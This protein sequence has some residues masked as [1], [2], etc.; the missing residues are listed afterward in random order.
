MAVYTQVSDAAL[1]EFLSGYDIGCPLS[2]KGIAEGVENSNYFLETSQGKF[3]LTLFE[4][5]TNPQDLPYF[6]GLKQHLAATGFPCP[7]PI[8]GTDGDAIRELE[9]RPAIIVSFLTGLSVEAPDVH[10]CGELGQ[11]MAKMHG[12]LTEFRMQRPNSLGP[13]SWPKLW[14]GRAKT[15]NTLRN[16]LGADIDEDLHAI[17]QANPNALNLP[18][19]TIHADLFP[20]NVFFMGSDFSGIID[21]YFACTGA[22]VYDIAICLNAW[23][24][25][26]VGTY[27]FDKGRALIAGYEAVR[28]L[29][30]AEKDALP[31]LARGAAIRFFLTRL[32]DWTDTPSDALVRP[33][34][35]LEYA[36]K[37]DWHRRYGESAENYG[38]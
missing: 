4:K 12:A 22:L 16:G 29:E 23:C 7:E 19:G 2:F 38:F 8:V 14:D 33:K 27:D 1:A 5:R 36:Q 26:K 24:F 20:D 10:Q 21:F 28:P 18:S 32:I 3:I 25:D 9:G 11:G 31:I 30:P 6:I 35:P 37:L 13:P 34:D 15:A 17:A